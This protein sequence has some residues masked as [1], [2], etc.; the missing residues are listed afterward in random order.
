MVGWH[1]Q[2]N[3]HELSKFQEGVWRTGKPGMLQ[4]IWSQ[5]VGYNWGTELNWNV[6]IPVQIQMLKSSHP[7]VMVLGCRTSALD[8]RSWKW[9]PHEWNECPYKRSQRAPSCFSPDRKEWEVSSVKLAREVFIR[10]WPCWHPDLPASRTV[11]NKCGLFRNRP[12]CSATVAW[13]D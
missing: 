13:T 1:H 7:K 2:L 12:A 4:S 5:R 8:L 3:G 11:R 9:G 10:I 6:C